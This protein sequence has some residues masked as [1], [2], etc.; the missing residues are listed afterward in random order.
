MDEIQNIKKLNLYFITSIEKDFYKTRNIEYISQSQN[1]KEFQY[2]EIY[3]GETKINDKIY[4]NKLNFISLEFPE[5]FNLK[6]NFILSK[7][8][9]GSK[10]YYY[11][12]NLDFN[13]KDI[14]EEQNIIFL[15]N[16][17][18]GELRKDNNQNNEKII[19]DAMV[20]IQISLLELQ[21]NTIS[22]KDI[23]FFEKFDF[24]LKG[25][26]SMKNNNE[27]ID[28]LLLDTFK[29]IENIYINKR[30]KIKFIELLKI[31]KV[32]I[33]SKEQNNNIIEKFNN[34]FKILLNNKLIFFEDIN[35]KYKEEY[36]S[37]FDSIKKENENIYQ[38]F[39]I[40][41]NLFY[42]YYEQDK[43]LL[44]Y[45]DNNENSKILSD[46]YKNNLYEPNNNQIKEK[47]IN[48]LITNCQSFEEFLDIINKNNNITQKLKTIINYFDIF[49]KILK[50]NDIKNKIFP[51]KLNDNL[52]SFL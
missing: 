8:K 51:I 3:S 33:K 15:Y 12:C 45:L 52:Q 31:S 32:I 27:I 1:I 14:K 30:T 41:I 49:K 44:K 35:E 7:V 29:E 23:N 25:I 21:E 46:L 10:F 38:K 4:I 50:E 17:K 40:I 42:G 20:N 26:A 43:I 2:S 28:N 47:L 39:I 24:F 19:K 48:I 34:L 18:I 37:L 5:K 13:F 36:S 9:K 22:Q 11:D 6:N 16:F